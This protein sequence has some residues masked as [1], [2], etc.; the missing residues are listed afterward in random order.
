MDF[1]RLL[2]SLDRHIES[3]A[4]NRPVEAQIGYTEYL[5]RH[6]SHR[7]F[8]PPA[9]FRRLFQNAEVVVTH[10]G[11]GIISSC[12]Q[13]GKRLVVVPRLKKF[14]EHTNNHQMELAREIEGQGLARVVYDMIKLPAAIREALRKDAPLKRKRREYQMRRLVKQYLDKLEEAG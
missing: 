7:Q 8:F 1:N 13:E 5:P 10:A 11:G 2:R 3:G 9:E 6:Y 4:I 14:G 12:L